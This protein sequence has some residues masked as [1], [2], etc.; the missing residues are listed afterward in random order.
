MFH[1]FPTN[2][3]LAQ[4]DGAGAK[5]FDNRSDAFQQL[6]GDGI[7]SMS[8]HSYP[9]KGQDGS[10]DCFL[11]M[12]AGLFRPFEKVPLPA[13]VECKDHDDTLQGLEKNITNG[14]EKVKSK[15][16]AQAAKGWHGRFEPWRRA[17]SYIYIVSAVIRTH[18]YRIKLEE[19]IKDFFTN[20]PDDQRLPLQHI[21]VLD[22]TDVRSWL[23]DL[24][25]VRDKW[26][27]TGMPSIL[28]LNQYRAGLIGFRRFLC[29]DG[30]PYRPPRNDSPFHPKTLFDRLGDPQTDMGILLVGPGGAGKTRTCYEVAL[31]AEKRGWCVLYVLPSDPPITAEELGENIIAQGSSRTLLIFE[32]VDQMQHFDLGFF[33]RSTIP[34]A[35]EAGIHLAY[36]ANSRPI[37]VKEKQDLDDSFTRVDLSLS[38]DE[39]NALSRWV[40]KRTAPKACEILSD[41][42]VFCICGHR[43]IISLL[44]AQQLEKLANAG[45]LTK[46]TVQPVRGE[47]PLGHWLR[48]RLCEDGLTIPRP[49]SI[50]EPISPPGYV[51]AAAAVLASAPDSENGLYAAAR[52]TLQELKIGTG[53]R[54]IVQNLRE[55]GWME[56]DNCWLSAAHD[57]VVDEIIELTIFE[58]RCVR[59]SELN[60]MLSIALSQIR[61][62]GNITKS[63]SRVQ[64][65][66]SNSRLCELRIESQHWLEKHAKQIGCM[67][68]NEAPNHG[69]YALGAV[70]G[71]S[72]FED[73]A[74]KLWSVIVAPWLKKYD[75]HFEARH[76]L[77]RGLNTVS[78][79][80]LCEL[81]KIAM[82]WLVSWHSEYAA[83]FVISALLNID[84]L[85]LEESGKL[86]SFA[87]GWLKNHGKKKEA[88]FVLRPLLGRKDLKE[89]DASR[90]VTHASAWLE[91][92]EVDIK[93]AF[94]VAPLL[95]RKDLKDAEARKAVTHALAWLEQHG[96]K[97]IA[98]FVL[99]PLL[100][101]KGLK[102]PEAN[103]AIT[104]ALV[105]LEQCRAEQEAEAVLGVL[106]KYAIANGKKSAAAIA[107]AMAWL[108]IHGI[109]ESAGFV[110]DPLLSNKK[111]NK[112][113][114]LK[115]ITY[116]V[117]WLGSHGRS[118]RADFVLNALLNHDSLNRVNARKAVTYAIAWLD[119][120][121]TS[122]RIGFV[123]RSLLSS[124]DVRGTDAGMVIE[125]AMI[126]LKSHSEA[127]CADFVL[128]PLLKH[129][130]INRV[131][132]EKATAY[133]TA[134]LT[135]YSDEEQ[136]GYLL[137]PLLCVKDLKQ[138]DADNVIMHAMAWMEKR[139]T[140]ENA[141]FV[142]GPLVR[143]KDLKEPDARQAV[144]H[145]T[146]W[147]EKHS[148]NRNAQAV[149]ASLLGRKDLKEP[150]ARQ[151]VMHAIAWLKKYSA[152]RNAQTVLASLLRRKDLK[153]LDARQAVMHAIAWLKKW[154][155][156]RV[157]RFVIAALL[158]QDIKEYTLA[159]EIAKCATLWLNTWSGAYHAGF[160][161]VPWFNSSFISIQQKVSLE[162]L[163]RIWASERGGLDEGGP[164]L[165]LDLHLSTTAASEKTE[166]IHVAYEWILAHLQ[167][168]YAPEVLIALLSLPDITERDTERYMKLI[169]YTEWQNRL[170]QVKRILRIAL[171]KLP[172]ESPLRTEIEACWRD[173]CYR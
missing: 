48:R 125:H 158:N 117:A 108:E 80:T 9:T 55:L 115:T 77:Y 145:A 37:F 19:R 143:R 82:K 39:S 20:L 29:N 90:A 149:L 67:I 54:I 122:D 169:T 34:R 41:H 53:G 147:L 16:S 6:I 126:W 31:M 92:C 8:G 10:I 4:M 146:A 161:F 148:A 27:G 121:A 21:M 50:W 105:W 139:G 159:E 93:A 132:K 102:D 107:H 173:R 69:S 172:K 38:D 91:Q 44:I 26:I 162:T 68:A 49:E 94:V 17:K 160:V 40:V 63:L 168:S 28:S 1:D 43:P 5:E 166:L 116:A 106:L 163:A 156:D 75:S 134:W 71:G 157:A 111:V 171:E 136:A 140:E 79:D 61:S 153:E 118:D 72:P 128:R 154:W 141:G 133:A 81:I 65:S 130:D 84:Q 3:N 119:S 101:R 89:P 57:V 167:N 59:V 99:A 78:G 51:V 138:V 100:D 97:R 170:S 47:D 144:M 74:I 15:L 165:V 2:F 150:D 66:I 155:R 127:D 30:L 96:T 64:G 109:K 123:L 88:A 70:F 137:D 58:G 24:K 98:G 46:T 152:N 112:A 13:I 56:K 42:E 86:F 83:S 60:A 33:R 52:L 76:L 142:L 120:H 95:G 35:R 12:D 25:D 104:L 14:W 164:A 87:I 135:K 18:D 113:D 85:K 7:L 124:R 103:S 32:Y 36:L 23:K 22:W 110:L 114:A 11:D 129:R 45:N 73:K 62:F 131:D 151:A